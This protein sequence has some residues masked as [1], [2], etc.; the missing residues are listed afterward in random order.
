M[1]VSKTDINIA[2]RYLEDALKLYAACGNSNRALNR[3]RLIKN[4]I[5]KLK[6]KIN[7]KTRH[8]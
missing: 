2:I 5:N 6:S 1:E 3:I 8:H 4:H 7:D